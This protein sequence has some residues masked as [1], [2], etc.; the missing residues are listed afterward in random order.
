MNVKVY[1]VSSS[2]LF[3]KMPWQK[4]AFILQLLLYFHRLGM[5]IPLPL[6]LKRQRWFVCLLLNFFLL[7][8]SSGLV[9][10]ENENISCLMLA[11]MGFGHSRGDKGDPFCPIQFAA[12]HWNRLPREVA[13]APSLP[14]F[15]EHLDNTLSHIVGFLGLSCAGPGIGL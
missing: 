10:Q 9:N 2:P 3:F 15:K 14:Q 13:T 5:E 8:L 6:A 1:Q 12:D 11:L 7:F 4:N